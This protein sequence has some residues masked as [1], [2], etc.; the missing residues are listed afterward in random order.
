MLK[1]TL[2]KFFKLDGLVDSFMGYIETRVELV[3]IEIREDLAHGIA[4]TVV[5]V[6][7]G[8]LAFLFI[9]LLSMGL[10]FYLGTLFQ[11]NPHIGF[12]IVGGFYVLVFFLVGL[13]RKP[14]EES[15]E[16]KFVD[17]IKL[18]KK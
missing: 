6:G 4:K 15:F 9:I 18:K 12:F 5:Y 17:I 11:G 3:K 8:L 2:L 1:D 7:L 14:I 16:K 10:A 13:F